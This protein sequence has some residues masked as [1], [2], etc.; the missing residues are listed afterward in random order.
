MPPTPVRQSVRTPVRPPLLFPAMEIITGKATAPSTTLTEVTADDISFQVRDSDG[1]C[2][3]TCA[4]NKNQTAGIAQ[5]RH[6]R[7]HDKI[8]GFRWRALTGEAFPRWPLGEMTYLRKT[9]KPIWEIT[10]SATA[11]DI[12][13][14]CGIHYYTN[15]AGFRQ[16]IITV[17]DFYAFAEKPLTIEN[18][19][20]VAAGGFTEEAINNPGDINNMEADTWYAIVGYM[21][22]VATCAA[23]TYKAPSLGGLRVGGPANMANPNITQTWFIDLAKKWDLP[24]IPCIRSNDNS[25]TYLGVVSDENTPTCIVTTLLRRL[26]PEFARI[27]K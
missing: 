12:E 26:K 4:W 2:F 18:S 3:I 24:A 22:N 15:L 10:G 17:K 13:R 5:I 19:V 25:L 1:N 11:G 27:A 21:V 6:E 9:D 8:N 7:M 14:L 16:N 20:T 23:I